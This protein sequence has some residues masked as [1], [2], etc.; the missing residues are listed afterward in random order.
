MNKK[1]P[2]DKIKALLDSSNLEDIKM[3]VLYLAKYDVEVIKKVLKNGYAHNCLDVPE[4]MPEHVIAAGLK[5]IIIYDSE[6]ELG[7]ISTY[8]HWKEQWRDPE[9]FF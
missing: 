4:F 3:G 7:A 5:S 6:I 9:E 2:I 8:Y 1:V